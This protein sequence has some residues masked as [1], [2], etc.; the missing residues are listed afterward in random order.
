[1]DYHRS[2]HIDS[3]VRH[4]AF[5]MGSILCKNLGAVSIQSCS[6][7]HIVCYFEIAVYQSEFSL[8]SIFCPQENTEEALL[9]LLISESMVSRRCFYIFLSLIPSVPVLT[10]HL[11]RT[12]TLSLQKQEE[13]FQGYLV[14]K[15]TTVV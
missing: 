3:S 4:P 2:K 14:G 5:L 12:V 13:H 9:L 1:M 10:W 6:W 11:I 7:L 15:I 8:Y